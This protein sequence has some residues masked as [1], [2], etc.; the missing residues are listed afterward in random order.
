MLAELIIRHG[1]TVIFDNV[2]T[3]DGQTVSLNIAQYI[4]YNLSI[5]GL[6]FQN[7]LFARVLKDAVEHSQDQGFS[8][9][10]R[11]HRDFAHGNVHL[12]GPVSPA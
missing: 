4:D 6:S 1:E 8:A 11:G 9:E 7:P 3:E 2:E 5:D 12:Y 10:Q